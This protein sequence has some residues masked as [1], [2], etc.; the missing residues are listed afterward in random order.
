MGS[1]SSK[2]DWQAQQQQLHHQRRLSEQ[3]HRPQHH[4][5]PQR[6]SSS[7]KGKQKSLDETRLYQTPVRS[8][9]TKR[10]HYA[11]AGI[12]EVAD[13][14]VPRAFIGEH[15]QFYYHQPAQIPLANPLPQ[16]PKDVYAIYDGTPSEFSPSRSRNPPPFNPLQLHTSDL[17]RSSS[18]KGKKV[19]R[20][21]TPFLPVREPSPS[22]TS[23][24]SASTSHPPP[25]VIIPTGYQNGIIVTP[26]PLETK[27]K[28]RR[29]FSWSSKS[30]RSKK[31]YRRSLD[32]PGFIPPPVEAPV[33]I[34][35]PA[36][37]PKPHTV[38]KQ[39]S[40]TGSGTSARPISPPYPLA[41]RHPVSAP[42]PILFYTPDQPH[43]GFTTFSP[44]RIFYKKHLYPT[45]EH[46]YQCMKFMPSKSHGGDPEVVELIR[47]SSENPLDAVYIGRQYNKR[48][49]ADWKDK[50]TH[51]MDE[52]L[53]LKFSQHGD[54]RHELI[55]TTPAEL[56]FISPADSFWGLGKHGAGQNE[57]GKS[58]GRVRNQLIKDL[59][60]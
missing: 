22:S 23:D 41:P 39:Q 51:W 7:H 59:T 60:T 29:W 32:Q 46:L 10:A 45:A 27:K 9:S 2:V 38:F 12:S 49:R 13:H 11:Q 40:S 44:H 6:S 52:I 31:E 48:A 43:Y 18:S 3:H 37:P 54:L 25:Q 24:S 50:R 34:G 36:P 20:D 55:N 15:G 17:K 58:L 14:Q 57:L 47:E 53:Y 5:H 33:A 42:A 30:S 21:Q 26:D 8:S 56:V 35:P 4:T 19:Q 28:K 1:G 16:P